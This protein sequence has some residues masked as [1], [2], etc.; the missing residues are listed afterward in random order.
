MPIKVPRAGAILMKQKKL[1]QSSIDSIFSIAKNPCDALLK[2]YRASVPDFD[3]A[4][5]LLGF[6]T[7][8]YNTAIYIIDKLN[9]LPHSTSSDAS[10]L[11][12]NQGFSSKANMK[13]WTADLTTL[14]LIFN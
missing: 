7:V 5:Q 10:L 3:K 11:W 2:L 12:L 13:D 8:S 9:A 14:K 6:P 1:S 4:T